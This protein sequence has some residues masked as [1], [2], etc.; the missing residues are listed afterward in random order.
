[1][2]DTPDR[3]WLE[4]D[5]LR[6]AVEQLHAEVSRGDVAPDEW[7]ARQ[8]GAILEQH[9]ADMSDDGPTRTDANGGS[10]VFECPVCG[11]EERHAY[12]PALQAW[13]TGH[14]YTEHPD[15]IPPITNSHE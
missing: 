7:F 4:A 6:D 1:M 10:H 8:L 15:E 13:V 11:R 12:Q 14:Y 5:T 9:A 2:T 3:P